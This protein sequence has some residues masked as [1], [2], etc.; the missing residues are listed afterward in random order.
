VL[1]LGRAMSNA[2][3]DERDMVCSEVYLKGSVGAGRQALG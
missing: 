2:R 3:F 1:N